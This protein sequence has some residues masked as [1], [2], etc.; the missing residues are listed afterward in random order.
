MPAPSIIHAA[1]LA[2]GTRVIGYG[3]VSEYT[4]VSSGSLEVQ[5][6]WVLK[7]VTALGLIMMEFVYGCELG[8]LSY[9]RRH[10]QSAIDLARKHNMGIIA[11]DLCRLLRSAEIGS[12]DAHVV[13]ACE[14]DGALQV[15]PV[16][17]ELAEFAA[18]DKLHHYQTEGRDLLQDP[19][20]LYLKTAATDLRVLGHAAI[21]DYAC[22]HSQ[23][24]SV[25]YRGCRHNPPPTCR[26]HISETRPTGVT[27]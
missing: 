3:R 2:V 26:R 5:K 21:A 27:R 20:L 17:T 16:V 25:Y 1:S 24:S 15:P 23:G 8:K 14:V 13:F 6:E 11:A 4:Q 10:L 22:S 7:E 19:F 12:D 18:V 9:H